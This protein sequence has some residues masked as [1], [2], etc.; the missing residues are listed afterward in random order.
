[1]DEIKSSTN[2]GMQFLRTPMTFPGNHVAA[3]QMFFVKREEFDLMQT[4]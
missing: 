3:L 4:R 2:V 1:M